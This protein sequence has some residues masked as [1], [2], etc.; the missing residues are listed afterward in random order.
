MSAR[1]RNAEKTREI[2]LEAARHLFAQQDISAVSIRDIAQEAGV[3]HGL[4]QQYLGNR[5]QMIATIIRAEVERIASTEHAPVP[6]DLSPEELKGFAADLLTGL[7]HFQDYAM[8]VMKAELAGLR[9]E[10]ML[11]PA[12]PTPA[13]IL[14]DAI[15]RLQTT[16]PPG[17]DLIDADLLSAYITASLFGFGAMAPWLMRSVGLSAEDY[18]KRLDEISLISAKLIG[19][20]CGG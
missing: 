10:D 18:E 17:S 12:M 2:I 11:D 5:E 8:L 20:A 14:A 7:E 19:L 9:P 15:R 16:C 3:S 6:A 4:V 1:E 13:M